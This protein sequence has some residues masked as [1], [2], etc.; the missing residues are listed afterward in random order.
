MGQL[1][2][3]IVVEVVFTARGGCRPHIYLQSLDM[4]GTTCAYRVSESSP[5]QMRFV[6][7]P[8][9][10]VSQ[11]IILGSSFIKLFL[12]SIGSMGGFLAKTVAVFVDIIL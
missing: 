11:L 9:L 12:S 1:D 6:H 8:V 10:S 5:L 3:R 2:R 4:L 7:L